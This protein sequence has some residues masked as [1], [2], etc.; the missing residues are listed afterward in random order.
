MTSL[1]YRAAGQHSR[2]IDSIPTGDRMP[3][4]VRVL[5]QSNFF[6]ARPDSYSALWGQLLLAAAGLLVG[7]LACSSAP[8]WGRLVTVSNLRAHLQSALFGFRTTQTLNL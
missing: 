8:P 4:P 5:L 2:A 3:D 6:A 7:A 1:R